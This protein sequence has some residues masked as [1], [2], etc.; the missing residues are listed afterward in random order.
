[1]DAKLGRASDTTSATAVY[2]FYHLAK[3]PQMVDKA[4]QELKPLLREDGTLNHKEAGSTV[5]VNG[6]INEALRMHPAVP[7]ALQRITPPEGLHIGDTYIPGNKTVWCPQ[8]A[9]GRGEW[10]PWTENCD[11]T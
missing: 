6:I 10:F 11:S 4:R 5:Y 2:M 8:Y 7:T 1:M 9:M 3:N